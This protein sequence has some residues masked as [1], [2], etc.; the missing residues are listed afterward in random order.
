MSGDA[1]LNL[2]AALARIPE[3]WSRVRVGSRAYGLTRTTHT[4]GRSVGLYAE[5]LGGTDVVSANVWWLA[6]GAVLKPC[7]MPA[8][9]VEAFLRGWRA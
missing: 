2:D 1:P 6:G 8:E 9:K 7:E 3:G 5:E 4:D